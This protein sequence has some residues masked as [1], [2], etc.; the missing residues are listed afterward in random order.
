MLKWH[1]LSLGPCGYFLCLGTYGCQFFV[2]PPDFIPEHGYL[3]EYE[4]R[5]VDTP[6][7][8]DVVA[9]GSP[10]AHSD[11]EACGAALPGVK[12]TSTTVAAAFAQYGL[13]P[14]LQMALLTAFE[15]GGGLGRSN[16]I[17]A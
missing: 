4:P 9:E 8:A 6:E 15:C 1:L 7:M 16:V 13:S 2:P 12:P 3:A 11:G 17:D 14:F 5:G 10:K